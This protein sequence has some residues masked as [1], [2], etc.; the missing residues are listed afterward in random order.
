LRESLISDDQPETRFAHP[1]RDAIPMTSSEAHIGSTAVP[2]L[3][4]KPVIDF[5]AASRHLRHPAGIAAASDLCYSA[6]PY[7]ADREHWNIA[8]LTPAGSRRRQGAI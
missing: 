5:M 6:W 3:A 2:G 8:W 1:A 7:Q 4:A